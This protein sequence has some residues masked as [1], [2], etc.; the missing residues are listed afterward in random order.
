M[1]KDF[2][3]AT[4]QKWNFSTP[5]F[6]SVTLGTFNDYM[7]KKRWVGASKNVDFIH[8]QGYKSPRKGG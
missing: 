1:V 2:F 6:S 8:I 4:H 3:I 7:D 5:S